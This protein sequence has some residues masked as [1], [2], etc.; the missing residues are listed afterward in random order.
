MLAADERDRAFEAALALNEALFS[1]PYRLPDLRLEDIEGYPF[2]G[3]APSTPDVSRV[4]STGED[5]E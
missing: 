3:E 5:S 2:A 4:Q 1:N